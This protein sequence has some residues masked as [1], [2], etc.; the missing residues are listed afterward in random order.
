MKKLLL[1]AIAIGIVSC[2]DPEG[3]KRALEAE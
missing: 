1:I 2:T 3:A